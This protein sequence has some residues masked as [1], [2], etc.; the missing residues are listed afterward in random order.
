MYI[1]FEGVDTV[2]KSTQINRIA[3]RFADVLV[4]REPGGT[5]LGRKIRSILLD[6]GDALP[7]S[8]LLLF[9]ADRA[10]HTERVIRPNLNRLILSDRSFISGI[11]Y[12]HVY[13]NIE[14]DTL[15]QLNRFAT[16]NTFPE[17]IVL[18]RIEEDEL[19][20]RMEQKKEDAIETRG[21]GYMLEVQKTMIELVD[22]LKI[23][24]IIVDAA[25]P[26]EILTEKIYSY[27]KDCYR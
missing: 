5:P 3:E 19:H 2:G 24:H 6:E 13:D 27:I 8:E 25:E 16:K 20:R 1:A 7:R 17:L 12:A 15:L 11:A 14:I 21:I 22:L 9:L 18:F 10:E 26:I 4:T 23:R